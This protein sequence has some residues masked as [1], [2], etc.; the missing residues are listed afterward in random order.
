MNKVLIK[1]AE[2]KAWNNYILS[3]RLI[4]GDAYSLTLKILTH[5]NNVNNVN[6]GVLCEDQFNKRNTLHNQNH[7]VFTL[8]SS[9]LWNNGEKV[10]EIEDA[11]FKYGEYIRIEADLIYDRIMFF[12]W[13]EYQDQAYH[14]MHLL[15][16]PLKQ[17]MTNTELYFFISLKD[18]DSQVK[19]VIQ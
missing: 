15:T 7:V 10:G 9:T 3:K 11:K 17:N 13:Q 16:T 8:R 5:E 6:V 18:P 12:K 4:P 19:L 14:W 1:T 2:Q